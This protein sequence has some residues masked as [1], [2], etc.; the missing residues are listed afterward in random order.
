MGKGMGGGL[1]VG[2]FSASH[3]LMR[4]FKDNPKLGHISTFGGNPVIAAASLATLR[5]LRDS[6]I[7]FQIKKKEALFRQELKHKKIKEIRGK[8]LM[9]A[10]IVENPET[11]NKII[12]K[13]LDKGL[14]L[15]WLLWE[16]NA[17]RISPSL[18]IKEKEIIFDE[19]QKVAYTSKSRR[20]WCQTYDTVDENF[21]KNIFLIIIFLIGST[22]MR[23][24]GCIINDIFD[25]D[26][27]K[28]V[29]RTKNRPI[30]SGEISIRDAFLLFL[31]LS[32]LGLTI[33]LSLNLLS[34]LIGFISFLL[35]IIYPLSKRV[36]YWPQLI[37]GITFNV[38]VLIGF[39]SA[40]GN[41]NFTI[42]FLYAA[43]IFWTL[44]YDTIYAVQ[45]IEDDLKIG[46]KSTALLF[47]KNVKAWVFFFYSSVLLM[48]T[49]FGAL[50]HQNLYYF[51]GLFFVA[52]LLYRQVK[53][54]SLDNPEICLSL[55]KSNQY[56]GLLICCAL[57]TTMIN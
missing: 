23:G 31:F 26:L 43:G 40:T 53:Y 9:L 42:L 34:I 38:G 56:V 8:G 44:G 49:I 35:L 47:G 36:T 10:L 19:E 37:L 15:F 41:I 1:P 52:L 4:L 48:L 5:E 14:I 50:S 24:A 22:V 28:S 27:D 46:I 29:S 57:L 55:F 13:C 6:Q 3:S 21:K 30:A 17:I 11:A 32:G 20:R 7:I 33:L 25:R 39:S 18:T 16:K 12:F 51:F 54:L 2:A 45:D